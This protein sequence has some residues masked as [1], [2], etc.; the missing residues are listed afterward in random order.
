MARVGKGI[1]R[2]QG[3]HAKSPAC[4]A[5]TCAWTDV[6]EGGLIFPEGMIQ[7][8]RTWVHSARAIGST[9]IDRAALVFMRAWVSR[10]QVKE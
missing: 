10:Q 6:P 8:L 3:S 9:L 2:I 1:E 7:V 5:C 4:T